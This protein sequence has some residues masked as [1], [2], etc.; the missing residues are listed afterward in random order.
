MDEKNTAPDPYLNKHGVKEELERIGI[1]K[2]CDETLKRSRNLRTVEKMFFDR[3]FPVF[4]MN[5]ELRIKRSVLLQCI[6]NMQKEALKGHKQ[7]RNSR[8]TE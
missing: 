8:G 1:L 6:E 7:K 2:P 4:M 5:G 3:V